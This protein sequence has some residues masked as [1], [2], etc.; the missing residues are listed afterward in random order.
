[1]VRLLNSMAEV[2]ARHSHANSRPTHFAFTKLTIMAA[3]CWCLCIYHSGVRPQVFRL[4]LRWN[5]SE[6][7]LLVPVLLV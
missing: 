2:I 4:I 3:R 5:N 1:M 6:R 7:G